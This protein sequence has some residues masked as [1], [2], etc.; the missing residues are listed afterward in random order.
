MSAAEL[1]VSLP[2]AL[3]PFVRS[4]PLGQAIETIGQLA[5]A[6]VAIE[7]VPRIEEPASRAGG[8]AETIP[9]QY[10]GQTKGYVTCRGAGAQPPAAGAARSVV[11]LM[12]HALDREMAVADLADAMN[13]SYEELNMLYTLMSEIVTRTYAPDIGQVVVDETVRILG[14]PAGFAACA[15]RRAPAAAG[16]GVPRAARGR[17]AVVRASDR[18]HRR[19]GHVR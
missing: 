10:R 17:H 19:T 4:A 5:G 1:H 16:A 3:V 12:E 13:T 15:G 18:H 6:R 8:A 7:C 11:T 2:E 9:I 14:L